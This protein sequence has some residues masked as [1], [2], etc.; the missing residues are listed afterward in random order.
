MNIKYFKIVLFNIILILLVIFCLNFYVYYSDITIDKY[1]DKDLKLIFKNF[2]SF[3][4]RDI[5]ESNTKN[6]LIYNENFRPV[7]NADNKLLP[8]IIL[9]GCSFA[10]GDGLKE[11]ETFSFKLG[12]LTQ[13]QIFNRAIGG[14]GIQHMLYQLKNKEFYQ[15]INEES[16]NFQPEFIIY[17]SFSGHFSRIYAPVCL[18]CPQCYYIFYKYDKK[19]KD[20]VERK[21]NFLTDKIIFYYPIISKIIWFIETR[22]DD[23]RS[24][25]L[26]NYLIA[27]K[28]EQ[29][30]NFE[31][32]KF[33]VVFYDNKLSDHY[34]NELTKNNFII[35]TDD[36]FKIDDNAKKYRLPDSH[37]SALVWEE[38]TP[39][40]VEKIQK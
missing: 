22:Y 17:L 35:I 19:L 40:I 39:R 10:Y 16:P 1:K 20:F 30:K 7:E 8:P 6:N 11:T 28:K 4:N 37:P 21:R 24:E 34:M 26:Y 38:I 9:F 29:E 18:F 25:I 31:T 23:K 32:S 36:D 3:M 33:V 5:S 15:Y 13:R 12:K 2:I 14:W 27:C